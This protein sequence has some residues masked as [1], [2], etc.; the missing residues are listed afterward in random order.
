MK[1]FCLN[2]PKTATTS[3]CNSF[4]KIGM[5]CMHEWLKFDTLPQTYI[6][7]GFESGKKSGCPKLIQKCIENNVRPLQWMYDLNIGA[8][9]QVEWSGEDSDS[10]FFPQI[11]YL[12][13]IISKHPEVFF[14]LSIQRR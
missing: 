7:M 10:N 8:V 3:L 1:V 4:N 2:L 9:T 6:R 13:E 11:E 12:G 5:R 14:Y